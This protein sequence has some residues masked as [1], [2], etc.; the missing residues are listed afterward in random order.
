LVLVTGEDLPVFGTLA[1]SI[2]GKFF[3]SVSG[4]LY[5][6]GNGGQLRTLHDL[7]R[8]EQGELGFKPALG[9]RFLAGVSELVEDRND[10]FGG[11]GGGG[12]LVFDILHGNPNA[13]K[14][15][16]DDFKLA[17]WS[18]AHVETVKSR[19]FVRVDCRRDELRDNFVHGC[20]L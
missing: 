12:G 10:G 7:D 19:D 15:G 2:F 16:E 13:G 1:R 14:I 8:M 6:L 9:L 4:P 11:H 3:G 20:F 17:S 18:P 5:A